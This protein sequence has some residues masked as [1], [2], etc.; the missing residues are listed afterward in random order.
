MRTNS[1]L[2]HYY[3]VQSKLQYGLAYEAAAATRMVAAASY[4][5]PH[6]QHSPVMSPYSHHMSHQHLEPHHQ[7][8]QHQISPA[9]QHM[10][11]GTTSNHQHL[12]LSPTSPTYIVPHES[13]FRYDRRLD[14]EPAPV[15]YSVHSHSMD[16]YHDM[17]DDIRSPKRKMVK[18]EE[19]SDH[20]PEMTVELDRGGGGHF[21][22]GGGPLLL[23][24]TTIP[25]HPYPRPRILIKNGLVDHTEM[26][27]QWNPSPPW[28][29]TTAQKVPDI[30]HQDLSPYVTTTP[31]TPT[32]TPTSMS[33]GSLSHQP[34][35]TAFTF[36]WT[37][38]QY[39]P[40]MQHAKVIALN[41]EEQ[42]IA[43]GWPTEHRLFPLQPPPPPRLLQPTSI[44]K[45]EHQESSDV[46]PRK[47]KVPFFNIP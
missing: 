25:L 4:Y 10:H 5:H 34:P 35:H 21:S 47:G 24:T 19:K 16:H 8:L 27:E 26:M 2:Y 36:D 15:D 29:D 13:S 6:S 18:M 9:M 28:S 23:S 43:H 46:S 44:V 32:G 14:P 7:Y 33:V 40:T 20:S 30:T 39:V 42:G 12:Q 45:M 31:P 41:E 3:M 22:S 1:W 11:N 38:E 37:A 17:V